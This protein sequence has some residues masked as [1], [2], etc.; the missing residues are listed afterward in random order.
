MD[1][2]MKKK[3][4]NLFPVLPF[5]NVLI[6]KPEI[7]KISNLELLQELPFYDDLSIAEISK[8][9]RRYVGSYRIEI[10]DS[11]EPL[12][13]LEA[14]KSSIEDLFKDLLN[15]MKDFRYQITVVIS[16]SKK[17]EMEMDK[18]NILIQYF[19][20]LTKTVINPDF[21]LDKSFQ[22][23]LYRIDNWINEGSGWII[24]SI[25]GEYVN[26]SKY[27]P[28]IGNSLF[29][30]PNEL[31]NS[32]KGLINIKNND[33]RC[34]LWCHVRHLNLIDKHPQKKKIEN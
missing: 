33:N 19:N 13:Q 18:L 20:S 8:A 15:E 6:E 14:S 2:G 1:F 32:K 26:I 22:E 23:I 11:K 16:L 27:T 28:L 9:F 17:K 30:L 5:D 10:I 12:I 7:K 31:N 24:N 34:F 29:E 3:Q 25:D 21:I 4:K